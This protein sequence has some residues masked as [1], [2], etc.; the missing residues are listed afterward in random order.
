MSG[1]P[2][3]LAGKRLVFT[4]WFYVRPGSFAWVNDRGEGVTVVGSEGPWGAHM[5][6]TDCP[7]GIRLVARPARRSGSIIKAEMP[8]E[9]GNPGYE[10]TTVM[11]DGDVYRA[12]GGN[13]CY[14]SGDGMNWTRPEL[15]IVEI[16]GSKRNNRTDFP[17]GSGTVFKDSSARDS[18]RYKWVSC[19][20]ISPEEFEAFKKKR[21][22]AW[23]PRAFRKDVGHIYAL[24]GA[25]SPD[26]INWTKLPEP[27]SVEHSDTQV[28][29]YYDERLR[30][31]VIYTRTY[32]IGEV[33]EQNK[34]DRFRAWWDAGRRS[35][36]RTESGDFRQSPV[37]EVILEPS[38]SMEPSDLLYTNCK[39]TIPGAPDHHLMFPAIWH[40]AMDDTTSIVLA[41]SH[42]G[43]VWNWV[44]GTAVLETAEFGEWDGGCVFARPNLIELPNGDFA[45]PYT[46]YIF[47]HKYPRGQW[48]LSTG[49]ALWPKGRLIALEAQQ[50]GEFAT[51]AIM[52]P[53]RKLRI[54]AVTR[55]GG[56]IRIEVAN[57]DREPVTGRTFADSI[58]IVGDQHRTPATWKG[59]EDVGTP[60]GAPIVLRFKLDRAS[61]YGLDFE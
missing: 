13:A 10:L 46:G 56:S 12:W 40:A 50:L 44:P 33:S 47:P 57:L 16:Q 31:Y 59:G 21:P 20:S 23:N 5:A 43:R 32:M 37:S 53:G 27:F 26:G 4:N 9:D 45:L 41:S 39:T 29:G 3:G 18:E 14:E 42:D 11:R 22:D 30:K 55:R 58:P 17:V 52:P 54:N 19:D 28:T 2:Y 1:E 25:V 7:R 35:I 61:I 15:G 60:D 38:P 24:V 49:Y 51:V 34:D 6:R 36:G 48:K 8:Y